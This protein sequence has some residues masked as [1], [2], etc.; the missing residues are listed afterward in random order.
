MCA[1]MVANDLDSAKRY[2]LLKQHG[3][4]AHISV[5]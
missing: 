1:E 2:A 5:E 3:H 4:S